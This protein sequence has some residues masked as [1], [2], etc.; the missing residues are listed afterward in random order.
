MLSKVTHAQRYSASFV[1]RAHGTAKEE[2]RAIGWSCGDSFNSVYDRELPFEALLGA[3]M[4]NA[5]K[6]ETHFCAQECLGM[7]L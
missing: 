3:G 1:M 7:S 4:Y 5:R 6:P 2:T